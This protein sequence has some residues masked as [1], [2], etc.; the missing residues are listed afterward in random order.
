MKSFK[1]YITESAH[2]AAPNTFYL[3][4]HGSVILP[5][6]KPLKRNYVDHAYIPIT[7]P[8]DFGL[9]ERAMDQLHDLNDMDRLQLYTHGE[10]G[11]QTSLQRHLAKLGYFQSS[12]YTN[13][14]N[15]SH[16]YIIQGH[17]HAHISDLQTAVRALRKAYPH[18]DEHVTME[19]HR[20]GPVERHE[21]HPDIEK[22][23][24]PEHVESLVNNGYIKFTNAEDIDRFAGLGTKVGRDPG[25]G[26]ERIPSP[27]EMMDKAGT[28]P[29][30][31]P[32]IRKGRFFT[33]DSYVPVLGLRAFIN[34]F[35]EH[36]DY[37]GNTLFAIGPDGKLRL[38]DSPPGQIREHP[39]S[40]PDLNFG[41]PTS[42]EANMDMVRDH[43]QRPKPIAHGRIDHK[44]RLIQIVTRHGGP[45]PY[46]DPEI[47]PMTG[48]R[49]SKRDIE[50]DTFNRLAVM[51]HLEPYK[52]FGI[53][54]S[55]S[56]YKH[57][58][59][60]F[61]QHEKYLAELLKQ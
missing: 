12:G 1:S 27:Q 49:K 41:G 36:E 6:S 5:K 38:K 50:E 20:I 32:S 14:N 47:R 42:W 30:E 34:E 26:V 33:G 29:N 44:K 4:K 9:S 37:E 48:S 39:D 40:F 28:D 31:P 3:S 59:H 46:G 54:V 18:Q 16:R 2:E 61:K 57:I 35:T 58:V 21:L 43:E 24:K 17:D 7:Q 56:D 60:S 22:S 53:Y 23:L 13:L 8:E 52:H 45:M 19:L 15:K 25:S 11:P 10:A 51:K 55:K